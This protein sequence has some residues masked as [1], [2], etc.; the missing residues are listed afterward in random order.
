MT[1]IALS[2]PWH[3]RTLDRLLDW[4]RAWAAQTEPTLRDLDDHTL[5]DLG[6]HRSEIASIEMEARQADIATTRR[7]IAVHRPSLRW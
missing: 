1:Y 2:T 3:R 4:L 7:R 5:R 6:I